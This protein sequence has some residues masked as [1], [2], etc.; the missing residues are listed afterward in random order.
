LAFSGIERPTQQ[1]TVG[2]LHVAEAFDNIRFVKT[3]LENTAKTSK[4]QKVSARRG[5]R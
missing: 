2:A 1:Q 3:F 5:R 4:K